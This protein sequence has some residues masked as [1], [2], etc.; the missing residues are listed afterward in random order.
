M[1]GIC[2]SVTLSIE[3]DRDDLLHKNLLHNLK[4]RGPN[5]SQQVLKTGTDYHCLFSGHVLHLRGLLTPQPI[6]DERGNVFLWNGEIFSGIDVAVEENDTQIMFN[7]LSSFNNESEIM[8]LFSSVHGPWA[9][10]Y[11]QASSHSVWFGRDYFGRRSL[12]WH[13]SNTGNGFCLASVG[14][15][16]A[17]IVNQWQEVPACG[18]FR[19]DLKSSAL[20]KHVVLKLYPWKCIS[21]EN[22]IEEVV[23]SLNLISDSLPPFVSIEINEARLCLNTPV[24]PLNKRLTQGSFDSHSHSSSIPATIENLQ[25]FLRDEHM[26]KQVHQLIHVL[27]EAVKRRVL[28]LT[29]TESQYVNDEFSK[30]SSKKANIAILFSGGIDSMVIASLADR[31]IPF[32][33]PIDLLNVA[34]MTKPTRH[35]ALTKKSSKPKKHLQTPSEENIKGL[36]TPT[37]NV[38]DQNFNVPD[39]LTGRAGL[40]E[41]KSLN[42]LRIWNFVEVNVTL[43]EL[44]RMR[45]HRINQLVHPLDTVLDDSIGCAVWFA[46][47]GIG[48]ITKEDEMQLYES[49]AKV[50]LTGIG[51]DEQLAGYSR[52]RVRFNTHGLEGL[53]KELE[54]ELDRISSRNLGRDDRVIGDH[55][56]EARFPFL[57][58]NVVSFLNSLSIL[59]KADL[60]LPRGI[61]EKL[62]LRLAALEL[63]L[64][65][66]TVLPKRAMQFGSKI[67]K[68]ENNNEKASEKC[69]RLQVLSE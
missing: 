4:R 31:H 14:T 37:D 7:H 51:A 3:R 18:I 63:G 38:Q 60:T 8:S 2:C 26:K 44:Q 61:G 52:H 1:C 23:R 35:T 12:L 22:I 54:M 5:S 53:N 29:R 33:E 47:R 62:I 34:F 16:A 42:P 20:S 15:Q 56:K 67:A 40:K 13:F 39:R 69:S 30:T 43:E 28:C 57:D 65:A 11:Y 19:I 25:I 58:E 64:T 59:E 48:Y 36:A 24:A 21:R 27:S 32:D 17:E 41:L 68:M 6:E 49:S 50:V 55:G 66:S 10:I 45:Q 9:F 46:S